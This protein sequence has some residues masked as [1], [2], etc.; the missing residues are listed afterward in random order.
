MLTPSIESISTVIETEA[1]F[2]ELITG[3]RARS[4]V[5]AFFGFNYSVP[6][7]N[8]IRDIETDD[9]FR[10]FLH[11]IDIFIARIDTGTNPRLGKLA[12]DYEVGTYP[13][14]ITLK[15]GKRTDK[16][17]AGELPLPRVFEYILDAYF[18]KPQR[19]TRER[20][21]LVN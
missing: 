13:T 3:D 4:H 17:I 7:Q 14:L 16:H 1:Q 18:P 15:N 9:I 6:S 20:V 12:D 10:Q 21:P 5:V 8:F 11:D 19:P 2:T